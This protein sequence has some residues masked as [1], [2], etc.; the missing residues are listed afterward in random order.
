LCGLLSLGTSEISAGATRGV[1]GVRAGSGVAF[2][3]TGGIVVEPGPTILIKSHEKS[4]GAWHDGDVQ[5][6][7]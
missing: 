3:G 1:A 7:K 5:E 6:A 2:A 4:S